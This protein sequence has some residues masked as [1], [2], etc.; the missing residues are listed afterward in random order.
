VLARLWASVAPPSRQRRDSLAGTDP[1]G[2][3]LGP[4]A[5][6]RLNGK[7]T[8]IAV[9][10]V[11]RRGGRR[12]A[13]DPPAGKSGPFLLAFASRCG[14]ASRAG[15]VVD[16]PAPSLDE[17]RRL[18]PRTRWRRK[19]GARRGGDELVA[20]PC[21]ELTRSA[22]GPRYRAKTWNAARGSGRELENG[23]LQHSPPRGRVAGGRGPAKP[24]H[25]HGLERLLPHWSPRRSACHCP[26]TPH[27]GRTDQ[28]PGSCGSPGRPP[29]R[30]RRSATVAHAAA[31]Q[32][33][34]TGT[35]LGRCLTSETRPR[36]RRQDF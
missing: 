8:G 23:R 12:A 20:S 17:R 30:T 26:G 32:T 3:R 16:S 31:E 14:R 11:Q 36:R 34:H 25:K 28:A 9:G 1:G 21:D 24:E 6:L 35:Q 19:L 5:E 4:S 18:W 10:A 29:L 33:L 15:Y 13:L 27:G 7:H 22:R 2:R